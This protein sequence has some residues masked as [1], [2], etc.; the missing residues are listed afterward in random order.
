MVLP[1]GKKT[2]HSRDN[3]I[4]HSKTV[5]FFWCIFGLLHSPCYVVRSRR[6]HVT[7]FHMHLLY[8]HVSDSLLG[9]KLI[10]SHMLHVC[11]ARI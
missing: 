1:K 7:E 4:F 5:S 9:S 11:V 2:S 6:L 10:S 3:Y 8:W